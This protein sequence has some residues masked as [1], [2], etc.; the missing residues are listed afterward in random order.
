M[1]P[2]AEG[3]GNGLSTVIF[4]APS[5]VKA[6]GL[7]APDL[8]SQHGDHRR[9]VSRRQGREQPK[10]V[11]PRRRACVVGQRGHRLI[12]KGAVPDVGAEV[13]RDV[14][15]LTRTQRRTVPSEILEV[16]E[17]GDRPR[18]SEAIARSLEGLCKRSRRSARSAGIPDRVVRPRTT[19][20]KWT[21]ASLRIIAEAGPSQREQ[22]IDRLADE[23][24]NTTPS[25]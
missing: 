6:D 17:L 24:T 21:A 12:Q 3:L 5:L 16:R 4:A 19:G 15:L 23:P 22:L 25:P 2:D 7:V 10:W 18:W 20:G 1:E 13:A 8:L 11:S 9:V 14:L